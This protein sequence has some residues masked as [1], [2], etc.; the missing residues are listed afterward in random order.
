[1]MSEKETETN[2]PGS[3]SDSEKHSRIAQGMFR[4]ML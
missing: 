2:N 1:M 4:E 3:S